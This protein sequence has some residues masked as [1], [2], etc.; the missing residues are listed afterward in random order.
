MPEKV[1]FVM[2]EKSST[3]KPS[4]QVSYEKGDAGFH[5]SNNDKHVESEEN[6]H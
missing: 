3:F 1:F 5:V 6:G 2:S 4:H